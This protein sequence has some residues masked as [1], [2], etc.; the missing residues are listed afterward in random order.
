MKYSILFFAIFT[1]QIYSQSNLDT[2]ISDLCNQ[3]AT[4]MSEYQKTTIAVIEFSDLDGNVTDL[5]KFLSEEVITKLFQTK[6]FKVIERQLLNKIIKEQKLQVSGIIDEASAKKLGKLLG[7]NAIVSGTIAE[8]ANSV[9]LNAR[10]IGTETGEIF[11]AA[12]IEIAKDESIVKLMAK[13]NG[14]DEIGSSTSKSEPIKSQSIKKIVAEGYSFELIQ[15]KLSGSR[16]TCELLITNTEQDRELL[17]S[18][19]MESPNSRIVDGEG[20]EYIAKQF[21]LGNNKGYHARTKLVTG[22]PTKV[23]IIFEDV[24][25][26]AN[27][28]SLLEIGGCTTGNYYK[29][30]T[31]QMRDIPIIKQ[32]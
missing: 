26:Q 30:F 24:S 1:T 5:G 28:L 23:N 2:Q 3:I 31:T 7:V 18:I 25:Q 9:K 13:V 19:P 14:N 32:K 17:L 20:N 11:G 6:K 8:L 4:E 29:Q 27:K 12:S 10:L 21:Q 16:L 15:C 22:I